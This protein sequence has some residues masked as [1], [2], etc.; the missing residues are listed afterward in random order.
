MSAFDEP[1]VPNDCVPHGFD[2]GVGVD[3]GATVGST[4]EAKIGATVGTTIR[5]TVGSTGRDTGRDTG[6]APGRATVHICNPLERTTV[7]RTTALFASFFCRIGRHSGSVT[8]C[9]GCNR[10]SASRTPFLRA[11]RRACTHPTGDGI[12]TPG[13]SRWRFSICFCASKPANC[14]ERIRA[15]ASQ[16]QAPLR[17]VGN[18]SSTVLR[19]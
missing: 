3:V 5:A 12:V 10:P 8:A 1:R 6:R 4:V 14:I 16:A 11:S 15:S 17:L 13:C 2:G 7:A 19:F 9:S 18:N